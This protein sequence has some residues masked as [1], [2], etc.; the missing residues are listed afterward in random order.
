M[1]IRPSSFLALVLIGGCAQAPISTTPTTT[2]ATEPASQQ[3][4]APV[5]PG[6]TLFENVRV[7]DGTS[8]QLS[9]PSNVLVVDNTIRTI[10]PGPITPPAGEAVTRVAGAGRVLMPGLI[11]NHIR[12]LAFRRVESIE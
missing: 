12:R 1:D 11:D 7:F 2:A 9:P 8:A 5:K 10:S 4:A 6:T 3:P